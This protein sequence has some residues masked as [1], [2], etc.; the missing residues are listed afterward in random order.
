MN[1]DIT[2]KLYQSEEDHC[3]SGP[4]LLVVLYGRGRCYFFKPCTCYRETDTEVKSQ[5]FE[6]TMAAE[7]H[8][9]DLKRK[10][11][12]NP[13]GDGDGEEEDEWVGPM[14]SEASQ[15]KKRKGLLVERMVVPLCLVTSSNFF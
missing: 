13:T 1:C 10:A 9:A 6:T 14:P 3:W 8:N 4:G 12:D 11:N 5:H 15:T 2:N 7:A